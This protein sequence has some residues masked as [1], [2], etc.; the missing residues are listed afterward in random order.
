MC[1]GIP[2]ETTR[3]R[4]LNLCRNKRVQVLGFFIGRDDAIVRD[5]CCFRELQPQSKTISG[6]WLCRRRIQYWGRVH[7]ETTEGREM[8]MCSRHL[9]NNVAH[10]SLKLEKHSHIGSIVG[11]PH[12]EQAPAGG[13]LQTETNAT[14]QNFNETAGHSSQKNSNIQSG[15]AGDAI[16][17][18]A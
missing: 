8:E 13:S 1:R 4:E 6:T 11:L 2:A 12:M 15:V 10:N 14:Q 9:C 17:L 5:R 18:Q 16:A 3:L 7:R